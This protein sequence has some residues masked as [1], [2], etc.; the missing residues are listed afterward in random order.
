MGVGKS[1]VG[2][3]LSARL[4]LPF[5]DLDEQIE[6]T[7]NKPIADIFLERGEAGFRELE[8]SSFDK[9][10]TKQSF[11]CA[12]GGGAVTQHSIRRA[13]QFGGRLVTLQA[14]ASVIA[15]RLNRTETAKRPCLSEGAVL[16]KL[17]TLAEARHHLYCEAH[18]VVEAGELTPENVAER[19]VRE[20]RTEKV[21]VPLGVRSYT[22]D[23]GSGVCVR[24]GSIAREASSCLVITD[25]NVARHWLNPVLKCLSEHQS[26]LHSTTFEAGEAHKNS[27]TVRILW[28]DALAS[29]LD[30][31]SLVVAL[32][33]GVAGDL[34]G[35]V[36]ATLFRGVRVLQL[37]TSVLAMVDSSVGGKTGFDHELGKNLIGAFHQPTSVLCDL[38]FLRTL[39]KEERISGLAEVA[40]AAWLDSE[41]SVSQ[42]EK[43]AEA[44]RE[45]DSEAMARAVKMAVALKARVVADD[46]KEGD[47]RRLLN[48]GH[49]VGHAIEAAGKYSAIRHG[50]AVSLGMVVAFRFAHARGRATDAMA[51]RARGLLQNLG[52]P[53]SVQNTAQVLPFLRQDKKRTGKSLAFVF[54]SKPGETVVDEVDLSELQDFLANNF[55]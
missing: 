2:R 42:L 12:L 19:L 38:D 14:P 45:G 28:D 51:S 5:V 18:D 25:T 23:I 6:A 44:L 49:T 24:A 17:H 55:P 29:G 1:T 47:A 21:V 50:E 4:G 46:E 8:R 39:P 11:V 15:G 30:R 22:V 16:E 26:N 43:D 34:G 41:E 40:K 7:T 9:L 52:L 37:P 20:F 13:A 32:G 53:T 48:L 36:A 54:P 3:V 31:K 33:G 35:F 27:E 10:N